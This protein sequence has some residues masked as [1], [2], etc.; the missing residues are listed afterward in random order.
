MLGGK[1]AGF[2]LSDA[3]LGDFALQD[4]ILIGPDL[5]GQR[6]GAASHPRARLGDL[7]LEGADPT[8]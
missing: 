3:A 7:T 4:Q 6:I 2:G 1:Q 5:R 8:I